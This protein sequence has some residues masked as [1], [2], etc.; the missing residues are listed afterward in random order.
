MEHPRG[1]H[2]VSRLPREADGRAAERVGIARG[3]R[4][5]TTDDLGALVTTFRKGWGESGGEAEAWFPCGLAWSCCGSDLLRRTLVSCGPTIPSDEALIRRRSQV[6]SA[7]WEAWNGNCFRTRLHMPAVKSDGR[8]TT[9]VHVPPQLIA[10]SPRQHSA[11]CRHHAVCLRVVARRPWHRWI[12]G[13]VGRSFC[14]G[15]RRPSLGHCRGWPRPG[16]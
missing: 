3:V 6:I 4:G 13:A 7:T 15:C 11:A 12:G 1:T 9:L 14:R 2:G 16:R 10:T 5:A 8:E